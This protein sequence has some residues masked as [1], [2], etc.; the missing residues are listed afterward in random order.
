MQWANMS[1]E[2]RDR[3]GGAQ[4]WSKKR[5][6]QWSTARSYLKLSGMTVQGAKKLTW[7]KN[8]GNISNPFY[9]AQP[10]SRRI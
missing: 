9:L 4:K 3:A 1:Q 2:E 10:T 8:S 7:L 5:G 6:F